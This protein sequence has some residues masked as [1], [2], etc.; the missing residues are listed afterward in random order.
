MDWSE[1]PQT[2]VMKR[3]SQPMFGSRNASSRKAKGNTIS[4]IFS[5]RQIL[6]GHSFLP[7]K[8]ANRASLKHLPSVK[9]LEVQQR[10]QTKASLFQVWVNQTQVA[11]FLEQAQADLMAQQLWQVLHDRASTAR[12]DW[13]S[14]QPARTNGL[15]SGKAGNTVLFVV[16]QPLAKFFNRS[17]DLIAIDW[18]NR[19]RVALNAEPLPLVKAQTQ[20][21]GL[22]ET[23]QKLEGIASWYGPYFHGRLTA[24]G[25]IFNQGDL[26]A[27]HPSLPFN[28]FLK[29]TNLVNGQSVIVRINDRGPYVG[30]RSLDLSRQAAH[31]LGGEKVGIIP[32]RALIMKPSRH[33]DRPIKQ[34][35]AV[36]YDLTATKFSESSKTR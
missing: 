28:T 23:Q 32:Y 35:I 19:L 13:D 12:F 34:A 3:R 18:V 24:T 11:E 20:M 26:T 31:Y 21:Y 17:S 27:A 14:L 30:D 1:Q 16:D 36:S 7:Q 29:V 22:T 15:P 10:Q 4:L 6:S 2:S 5:S 33:E 8:Y 25:E 9:V